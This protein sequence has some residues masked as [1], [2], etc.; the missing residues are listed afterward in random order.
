VAERYIRRT[1]ADWMKRQVRGLGSLVA[2]AGIVMGVLF[3]AVFSLG[4]ASGEQERCG[5][6]P[7]RRHRR[8]FG[9]PRDAVRVAVALHPGAH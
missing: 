4:T 9:L 3:Y 6:Q 8:P 1:L 7:R 2:A 5:S